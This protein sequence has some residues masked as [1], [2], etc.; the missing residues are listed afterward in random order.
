MGTAV[1][2]ESAQFT[3][4]YTA[5][6]AAGDD[7]LIMAQ[8]V[9]QEGNDNGLLLSLIEAV[10]R[11]CGQRPQRVSPDSGF[12]LNDNVLAM[13]Q[14]SI[15]G[16]VPDS[17]LARVLNRGGKLHL[18]AN[19]PAHQRMRRKLCLPVGGAIY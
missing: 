16:Y 12:F 10:R 7:R 19:Q 5:T 8:Q 14:E 9:S 17:N 1:F 6:V 3:L 18:P 15:D 13:E 11:S 2:Y 4:G